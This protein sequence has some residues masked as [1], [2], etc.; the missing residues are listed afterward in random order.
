MTA[1]MQRQLTFSRTVDRIN[2]FVGRAMVW[3]LLASVFISAGNAF[4]RKFF[5]LSSNAWIEAQWHLFAVA[6]LG[7]AGYVLL[8]DEHVR[9]DALSSRWSARTRAAIDAAVLVLA[10]VPMTLLFA[11]HGWSV[12]VHAWRSGETSFNAGGLAVWPIYLCI[13][14]G[15]A[16]LGLQAVSELI[17]RIAF[18]QG[19]VERASLSEA[20]MPPMVGA[21]AGGGDPTR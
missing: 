19:R 9:V 2:R 10:A 13:P 18:L 8:V 21:S 5:S 3:P 17:R 1:S 4:S 6:F 7:C 20:D 11:I 15:M 16:L 14:L 12:F